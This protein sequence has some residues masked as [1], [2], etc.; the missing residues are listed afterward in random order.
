MMS[1]WR[2]I[3]HQLDAEYQAVLEVNTLVLS[4]NKIPPE[5]SA[6]EL[7]EYANIQSRGGVIDIACRQFAK[8]GGW[9]AM[10]PM[11]AR[12]ILVRLHVARDFAKF[13]SRPEQPEPNPPVGSY[14]DKE[15]M[16][17]WILTDYWFRAGMW[18]A[19]YGNESK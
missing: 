17:V 7:Q 6:I 8:G 10:T 12:L 19:I 13:I 16:L 18:Q 5:V 11:V 3:F 2:E 15:D 4:G 9:P 14:S 1:V